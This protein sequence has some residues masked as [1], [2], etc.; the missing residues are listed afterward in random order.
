LNLIEETVL[1]EDMIR[2]HGSD[3]AVKASDKACLKAEQGNEHD[4]AKWRRVMVAITELSRPAR[5]MN[6]AVASSG[7]PASS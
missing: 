1:A 5:A 2:R 7:M 6:A 3:A 4:A